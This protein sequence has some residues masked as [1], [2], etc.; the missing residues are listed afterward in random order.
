VAQ[1]LE[2]AALAHRMSGLVLLVSNPF[3][4]DLKGELGDAAR[5]LPKR[6]VPVD[7]TTYRHA[8]LEHRVAQAFGVPSAE[9]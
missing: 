5:R 7:L 9:A 3:L 2:V 8:E 4:G 6:S 1:Q